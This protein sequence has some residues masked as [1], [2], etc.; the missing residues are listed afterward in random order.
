[1]EAVS[2]ALFDLTKY[3]IISRINTG[4]KTFDN[5]VVTMLLAILTILT[6]K[7]IQLWGMYLFYSVKHRCV[8]AEKSFLTEKN[9]VYY[10]HVIESYPRHKLSVCVWS[11]SV[12]SALYHFMV[13]SLICCGTNI[14]TITDQFVL[15]DPSESRGAYSS[16]SIYES[17]ALLLEKFVQ[18]R[19]AD[20]EPLYAS[21]KGIVG[22]GW[23]NTS[24]G[25]ALYATTVDV[26]TEFINLLKLLFAEQEK[27]RINVIEKSK[28]RRK[29]N[30]IIPGPSSYQ[31]THEIYPD[32]NFQNFIS[33]YKKAIISLTDAFVE[34]NN[35]GTTKSWRQSIGSYNLGFIIHG[36]PGTGKTTVIKC[37]CN[38]LQRDAIIIDLR[39]VKTKSAFASIFVNHSIKNNIFV[40]EE[41]D[42][43]QGIFDR[44]EVDRTVE[45]HDL[46]NAYRTMLSTL[47]TSDPSS[48]EAI[49]KELLAIKTK[50]SNI[51]NAL[52]V[53]TM[54]TVLDGMIEH[55]NR[56]II[57]STNHIDKIDPA[58]IREGRFD[59]KIKLGLF[60]NN[61][62]HELL[63]KYYSDDDL[64]YLTDKEFPVQYT[65]VQLINMCRQHESLQSIVNFL[66]HKKAD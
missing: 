57:A 58:L 7:K 49:E 55:R 33:D 53:D 42:C 61:E 23:D 47:S 2:G 36:L 62:T 10:K 40:F 32:R 20:I 27:S 65:P 11:T 1:M 28:E 54:L 38:Y 66:L 31:D 15:N 9:R 24:G 17:L 30:I 34:M 45:L 18:A 50:I 13:N 25:Y 21:S 56:V 26:Q 5:L 29:L 4:D 39:T 3:S 43:V 22:M 14:R 51:E 48:K 44:K 8:K 60:S 12:A 19:S 52:T 16:R 6:V 35:P 63:R 64:S 46:N 37:L 41:F 59:M